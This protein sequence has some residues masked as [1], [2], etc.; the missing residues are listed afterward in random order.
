MNFA[1]IV[2]LL[3][4]LIPSA[5]SLYQQLENANQTG[6]T[7]AQLLSQANVNW[8]D[9]IAAAQSGTTSTPAP[10]PVTGAA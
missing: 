10:Q 5:I 7:T 1:A 9:V 6:Q 4:T 3:E 2:Q 8:Q